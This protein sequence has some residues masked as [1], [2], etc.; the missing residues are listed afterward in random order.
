VS[1]IMLEGP[2]G[3]ASVESLPML[4]FHIASAASINIFL[5]SMVD[6]A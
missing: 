3:D 2:S 6:Q 5:P 4:S 1:V